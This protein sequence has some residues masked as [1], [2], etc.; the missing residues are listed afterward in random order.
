[1]PP[2]NLS[3][4]LTASPKKSLADDIVVRLRQ[5]IASGKLA[6]GERLQEQHVAES[7]GVSRGPVRE[8]LLVLEREGLVV[9]NH[10]RGAVVARLSREDLD[11]VF[12]LRLALERLAIQRAVRHAQPAHYAALQAVLDQM[13]VF[14]QRGITEQESADLDLAFHEILYQASRHQ[15]LLDAWMTLKPQI[16]IFLLSRNVA[17]WD[18]RETIVSTHETLYDAVRGQDEAAA[19]AKIEVHVHE[20]YR[21]IVADYQPYHTPPA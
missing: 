15:R 13:A 4:V 16:H 8:A 10:N 21:R 18:F 9:K 14:V 6:P 2:S 19:V 20:A 7:L 17:H 1:M 12:S 3:A 5:A 11:E